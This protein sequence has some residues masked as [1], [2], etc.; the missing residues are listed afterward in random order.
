MWHDPKAASIWHPGWK[1]T[2]DYKY[3]KIG[4]GTRRVLQMKLFDIPWK[5]SA[6]RFQDPKLTGWDG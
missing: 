6:Q 5:V 1:R 3:G 4:L 2:D